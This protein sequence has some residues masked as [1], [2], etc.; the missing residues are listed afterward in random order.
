MKLWESARIALRALRVNKLRSTLT[1][2]GTII[3]VGAVI[4]MVGVGAGAQASVAER[5]ASLGSTLIIATAGSVTTRGVRL[6]QGT[7]YTLTEDDAAAVVREIQAVEVAV[8]YV[9]DK[10]QVVFG[11]LNWSTDIYGVPPDY[12][13]AHDWALA[14]G[15]P[16]KREDLEGATT[17]AII[18]QTTALNLF[19]EANPLGQIIRVH[20]VPFT[21]IGVLAEKG[22]SGYDGWDQDDRVLIPLSTAKKKVLGVALSNPRSVRK[23]D[24]KIWPDADMAA[25]QAQIRA[26][27][28]QRHRLRPGENDDFRLGSLT[29]V[30]ETKEQAAQIMTYLLAAVA[31]VSLL[32]GGI[33][34]MN[35]ML[36][37]VTERTREIGLRMA[38]GAQ[39]RDILVQFLVEAV[40]L[41]M[42][43]GVLGIA[44]GLTSSF[45]ISYFA[46]WR[47]L[48]SPDTIVLAFSFS[49]AVGVSFGFYPAR[50]AARLDPIEALRYE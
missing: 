9:K 13:E 41:S 38:V 18:G 33:G 36:V 1:M 4:T 3:G 40:T 48:V 42:V 15:R 26:L 16:F 7:D 14:A 28:R 30:L 8:P 44:A 50:K 24:I 39:G 22:E 27:L 45:A 10:G 12:L 47:T 31:S 6:G 46:E 35:I 20:S 17:L 34:I 5:I 19:G 21:I 25:A 23:V 2:L 11:N 43:G 37:S 29:A 49:A 32:V